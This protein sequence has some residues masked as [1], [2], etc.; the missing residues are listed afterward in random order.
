M[1]LIKSL[2]RINSVYEDDAKSNSDSIINAILR[3]NQ[4]A[5]VSPVTSY[6]W[7]EKS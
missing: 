4:A 6:Q 5:R 3:Q 1:I 2:A 7:A